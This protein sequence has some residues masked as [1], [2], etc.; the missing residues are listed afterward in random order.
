MFDFLKPVTISYGIT[1]CNESKE[2]CKLLDVLLPL[3]DKKDEV[4]ILRDMTAPDQKVGEVLENY[5]SKVKIIEAQLN[6]DFATFKN[7]LIKHAE[8]RYLFQIDADE[9]PE[10]DLIKTLK[11]YLRKESRGD[12][13]FVPRI[14]IVD[15]ITEDYI[16][17]MKW[18]INEMGY[19]N[20]PDYQPRIIKN[21]K[22]I[23]WKNKVHETFYGYRKVK[24]IPAENNLCLIHRKDVEK[25]KKQNE[26]Y[27]TLT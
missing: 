8:C 7:N 16:R 6:G 26:F 20:F 11:A 14:N 10:E 17:K 15:G 13:F 22:N 12:C 2:L 5:K 1:V 18:D 24:Y 4:I 21:N 19:I 25:Q 3:I 9:Y 27:D 23:F